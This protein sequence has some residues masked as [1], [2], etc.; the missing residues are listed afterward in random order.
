[1]QCV[2][3]K[4]VMMEVVEVGKAERGGEPFSAAILMAYAVGDNGCSCI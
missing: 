4:R 2:M 3:N 1:M